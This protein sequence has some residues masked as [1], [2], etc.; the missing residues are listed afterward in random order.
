MPTP[1]DYLHRDLIEEMS[2]LLKGED[3]DFS[4]DGYPFLHLVIAGDTYETRLRHR[5]GSILT[6][7]VNAHHLCEEVVAC[8][9]VTNN[10][11]D[12]LHD[13]QA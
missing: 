1:V 6:L 12:A 8:L 3:H 7:T 10:I 9:K 11:L 4:L 2:L 13:A 5:D